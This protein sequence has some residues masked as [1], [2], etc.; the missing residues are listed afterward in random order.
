[1]ARFEEKCDRGVLRDIIL[2]PNWLLRLSNT[3]KRR[4]QHNLNPVL[5]NTINS[6]NINL[7]GITQ[8]SNSCSLPS[9]SNGET[10]KTKKKVFN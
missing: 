6:T 1:M 5:S 10:K 7:T 3:R 2:P 9:A 4:K 8:F